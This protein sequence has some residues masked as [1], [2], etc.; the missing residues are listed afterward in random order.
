MGC[1]ACGKPLS[2]R[3]VSGL[4]RRH[5]LTLASQPVH[6][7]KRIG[8]LRQF[9]A[10]NPDRVREYCTKA[11]RS[12]LEWCPPEYRDE[13]RHLTRKKQIPA[14]TA[15]QIIEDL[16]ATHAARYSR[17]GELQQAA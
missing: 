4:C 17:T 13:Y 8:A 3:N 1:S 2:R 10:N 9:A 12:R 15:R 5:A 7:A 14:P 6:M 16:I 11:S